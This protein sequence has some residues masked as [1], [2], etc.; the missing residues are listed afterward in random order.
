[1]YK[2]IK[3][4]MI[5]LLCTG[6]FSCA[7][8]E[9]EAEENMEIEEISVPSITAETITAL[10]EAKW[11]VETNFPDHLNYVDDTLAL[12]SIIGF[13]GYKDQGELYLQ[14]NSDLKS[15]NLFINSGDFH[16]EDLKKGDLYK[17][18]YK[19]FALNGRNSLQISSLNG[20]ELENCISVYIPYPSVI[21]GELKD[22]GFHE[23]CF[24][25]ISDIIDADIEHG[26]PS[27]QLA[28]IRHNKLVYNRTWGYLNSYDQ[29]GQPLTDKIPADNDT[30]Y[31][32]AS[33]TKMF[34]TNYAL[35]KLVSEGKIDPEDK[36]S[37]YLGDSFYEDTL[38]FCYSFGEQVD[39][40]TMKEWKASLTLADLLKH[41]A[42]F[43]PTPRY[44]NIHIDAISQDY[45]EDYENLLYAGSEHSEETKQN[46]I[47]AICK[48]PLVYKPG[49]DTV[50]SDVDYMILGAIVEIVSEMPLDQY[51]KENFFTPLG[52]TR[53]SFNPLDNGYVKDDCAATELNGNTR[54]H[55]VY[56]PGIRDYTLQGEVHDEQSWFS[57][58]GVSGHAGLFSN[59]KDL[60]TLATLMFNGGYGYER[61][62]SRNVID[63]FTAPKSVNN[64]NYGLG[65]ARQGE[66]KRVWYYGTSAASS[67]IGHQ[68]WTGTLVMIDPERD[69][70]MVYLTNSINTPLTNKEA[71]ANG[72]RGGWYT[73]ATLGFVPELFSIGLDE[74][75]DVTDQLISLLHEMTADSFK[76][77]PEDVDIS[78]PA[79]ESAQGIMDVYKKW[80]DKTDKDSFKEEYNETENRWK[81]ILNGH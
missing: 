50:Y 21:E 6:L 38:D 67:T 63:Y 9:S 37:T 70:V 32:L 74:E 33:V 28:I 4:L 72:F 31:D 35:Q 51:L 23:E 61:F 8:K 14:I 54:D 46:T 56:F 10:P 78:H 1:M 52:L 57:M 22:E 30:M 81:E 16:L 39:L 2:Y 3:I 43:P 80:I 71:N 64:S 42:G 24:E 66:D 75:K 18:S 19:D 53:I 7:K 17:I 40:E 79:Y 41:E 68:G 44:F 29:N 62:F 36:V 76:L 47:K 25:L 58:N 5:I 27:A 60:A 77:I 15:F 26:F 55:V 49:S 12:N 48:T 45:G 73:A 69:I 59:A 20:S 65:W 11:Q 34:A 13:D